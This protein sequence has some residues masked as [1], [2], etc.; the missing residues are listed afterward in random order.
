MSFDAV[1]YEPATLHYELG[2]MLQSKYESLPWIEIE[3]HN[4]IPELTA[5]ENRDFPKLKQHLIIG[6]RKTHKYVP[7]SKVS[8]WLVPY[9]SSGCRAMCLYCYLVCNYNKCAY[10]R[11]FVNREQMLDRLLKKDAEAPVPQTF[12]IGSNSDLVLENAVTDN[13]IDTIERFAREGRGHLTFPTKF[14]LVKPLLSLDHKG[15]TIFRMSINPEEIIRRIELGTSPL[16][17]RIHALNEMAD[18]GYPAGMLIAPVILVPEWKRLYGELIEQLAEELSQRVKQNG[19]IEII[20]MT[21]SFVQNAINTDAFPNG[22]KLLNR[23]TMT[24]RGRGKYCYRN[25]IRG[26]A[27]LFLR[28]KL[29]KELPSMSILYI[30]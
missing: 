6:V 11:L 4:R 16:R 18:A 8:D 28:E 5:A 27:E 29:S 24:G 19:F 3:S 1:Y 20:L 30:S 23:D 12:E 17:E 10:L 15:K 26:E 21:Y 9:T 7:N 13:L 14:D 25:D 22:V 2:K